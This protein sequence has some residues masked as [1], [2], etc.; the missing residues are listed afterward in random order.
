MSDGPG[1]TPDISDSEILNVF[2]A[3]SEPVLTTSEVAASFEITHRGVRDRLEKLEEEDMLESKKV[4]ARAIVW[5]D[6][7]HTTTK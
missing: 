6:P 3:S 7:E 1:R 4:G 2:R 5:W